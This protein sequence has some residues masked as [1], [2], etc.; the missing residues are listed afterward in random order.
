M[1]LVT[2]PL[3]QPDTGEPLDILACVR[4]LS[5]GQTG[6]WP[7]Q[8]AIKARR[9]GKTQQIISGRLCA[10]RKSAAAAAKARE[11]VRRES[12]RNGTQLQPQTL[13]AAQYVLV[14]TTLPDEMTATGVMEIYR[15]RWQIELEFKRLK[16]LIQ[17]GHLKKHDERAARSWL[18]GKLLV[19]LLIARL[20][21]H[22][23]RFSPWGYDIA[24]F[25]ATQ[26]SVSVA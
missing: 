4:T 8:V 15:L 20:I 9:E 1:N 7:A 5:V 13:E 12:V 26:R 17:L 19:A 3:Q 10:V 24:W 2:L 18:Q 11:R 16:S 23:E 25:A 6:H 21:A 22:A 14:F